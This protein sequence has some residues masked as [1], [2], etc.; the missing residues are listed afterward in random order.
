MGLYKQRQRLGFYE[1]QGI[2]RTGELLSAAEGLLP[3]TLKSCV[4][5]SIQQSPSWGADSSLSS[6][7]FPRGLWNPNG[8]RRRVHK[9]PPPILILSQNNSVHAFLFYLFKVPYNIILP[10]TSG[11]FKCPLSLR[12]PSQIPVCNFP[13][14][15]TCHIPYPSRFLHL[16]TRIICEEY[17]SWSSSLCFFLHSPV[18]SS[19]L[20]R[21]IFRSTLFY[22]FFLNVRDQDKICIRPAKY[23]IISNALYFIQDF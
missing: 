10:S 14:L 21:N 12:L 16:I 8:R 13:F 3:V 23:I 4:T 6:Q 17:R 5:N 18:T 7:N 11:S 22:S 20:G 2:P 1:Q 19:L 15:Q 9:R